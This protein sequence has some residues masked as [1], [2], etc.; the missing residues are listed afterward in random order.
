MKN[1]VKVYSLSVVCLTLLLCVLRILALLTAYDAEVGYWEND[2]VVILMRTLYAVTIIWGLSPLILIPK[3][4]IACSSRQ[5]PLCLAACFTATAAFFVCGISLSV[6]AA[7]LTL[8][9]GILMLTSSLFFVF[10]M[11]NSRVAQNGRGW[12]GFL[13]ITCLLTMLFDTYFNMYIPINSPHKHA[14]QLCILTS[15]VFLLCEIRTHI[16]KSAPR[17]TLAAG[18]LCL[19]TTLPTAIGNL[20]FYNIPHDSF[21]DNAVTPLY[22]L[23]LLALGLYAGSRLLLFQNFASSHTDEKIQKKSQEPL[24]K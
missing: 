6:G 18:L 19:T 10:E 15:L 16:G 9:N 8:A 14:L 23:P 4:S 17:A 12:L 1:K 20:V 3:N 2:F 24:D 5:C 7:K 22:A 21:A 13:P 11:V